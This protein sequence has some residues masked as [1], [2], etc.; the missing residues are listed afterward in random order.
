MLEGP[1]MGGFMLKASTGVLT[2]IDDNV[3]KPD[4]ASYLTHTG[5]GEGQN[6]DGNNLRE[7]SFNWTA[8]DS[9]SVVTEFMIYGNSVNGNAYEE[10]A[11]MGTSGDY[12]NSATFLLAGKNAQIADEGAHGELSGPKKLI[13]GFGIVFV[14]LAVV[15]VGYRMVDKEESFEEVMK[16]YWKWIYPWLTTTDHKYIGTLYIVTG[17]AWF[18]IGGILGLL[19]RWQLFA[20]RMDGDFLT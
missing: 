5:G 6:G 1:N 10:S 17:F 7:W 12:W 15:V 8:P 13:Y 19:I 18:F 14:T 3:W 16:N 11:G 9:D 20:P 4:G 2:P